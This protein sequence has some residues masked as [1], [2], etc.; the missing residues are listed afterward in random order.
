MKLKEIIR[1]I[2]KNIR[3]EILLFIIFLVFICISFLNK[4]VLS[5]FQEINQNFWCLFDN[6][7]LSLITDFFA[8]TIGI[9]I[10]VTTLVATS[11][12]GISRKML[13]KKLDKQILTF[14]IIGLLENLITII[15]C[16]LENCLMFY[17]LLFFMLI[18]LVT[19]IKF[20]Y[21]IIKMFNA[22]MDQMT[23]DFDKDDERS[24]YLINLLEK[25]EKNTKINKSHKG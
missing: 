4:K 19:L 21:L 2:F 1:F 18:S 6:N 24:N 22:N 11:V 9:Y 14:L 25:I 8:I 17:F 20:I 13:E 7:K 5:C 10:A 16:I 23:K 3:I 15:F 12:I